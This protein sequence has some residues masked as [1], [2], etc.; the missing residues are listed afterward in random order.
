M[1]DSQSRY[2]IMEELNA[3]KLNEMQALTILET[4]KE[5]GEREREERINSVELQIKIQE[6]EVK[7]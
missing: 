4:Q 7:L 1:G 5:N 3:K 2:G 6:K